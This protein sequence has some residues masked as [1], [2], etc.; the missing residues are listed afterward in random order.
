MNMLISRQRL[1]V[2]LNELYYSRGSTI[3]ISYPSIDLIYSITVGERCDL[4]ILNKTEYDR[5]RIDAIGA[6]EEFRN[7]IPNYNNYIDTLTSSGILPP[8]NAKEIEAEIREK[9]KR[10]IFK[11]DK[12]LFIGFDTN[13]LM[14]RLNRMILDLYGNKGGICLSYLL[15][16]ELAR[17]WDRKYTFEKLQDLPQ[18]IA[19]MKNFPNQPLLSA[20]QARLGSVEYRLIRNNPHTRE[21]MAGDGAD[22]QIVDSYKKFEKDNDVDVVLVS[23]DMNF[24]GMV[25]D[26]HMN[27]IQVK[28]QND[29]PERIGIGWEHAVELIYTSAILY[30]YILMN[31]IDIYGIWTGKTDDDWNAENLSITLEGELARKIKRDMEIL[32]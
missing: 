6:I 1:M 2:L 31:G 24:A 21:I 17:K 16:R 19:F 8:K 9:C 23:G 11:G 26:A 20:R 3:E 4:I 27:V 22:Q 15:S 7:E 32:Q 25:R 5:R 28:K 12:M 14:Y 18:Q 29:A 30:G 13:I 10:D